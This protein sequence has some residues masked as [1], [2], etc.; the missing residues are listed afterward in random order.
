MAAIEG[1]MP[2]ANS[3]V[4]FEAAA[5]H[6]SITLAA[7]EL[8]VTCA[9]VSRQVRKLEAY[10]GCA[11]FERLHRRLRLTP[12]G[13]ML[14]RAL[15]EGLGAIGLAC[16]DLATGT[17]AR[18]VTVG[19]TIAFASL[20]LMPRIPSFSAAN[21]DVGLRYVVADTLVD[22]LDDELDLV[23]L[24]GHGHWPG[25]VATLLFG[26]EIIP[27]CSPAYRAERPGLA[28]PADLL[29]ER[30]IHVESENRTWETWPIWFAKM[31]VTEPA[32]GRAE[33][34]NNY[35]MALQAAVESHGVV[36]GWR[37]LIAEHLARGMLVPAVPGGIPAAGG[38]YQLLP[39]NRPASAPTRLLRDW[40]AREAAAM[41]V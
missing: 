1:Q 7:A 5:R 33:R 21:P 3:L 40:I 17:D 30:L 6:Q 12:Q 28:R 15:T 2:P 9:A 16:R 35:M 13:A 37:R 32:H 22:R 18:Q 29:G 24:Y 25:Y 4:A 23:V 27:V 41:A 26:D 19:S 38:Y 34:F 36:L 10:L 11:L 8:N 31:G 14:Q 39:M 20:W